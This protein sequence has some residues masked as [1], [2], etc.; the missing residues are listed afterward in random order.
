MTLD[1]LKENQNDFY[2]ELPAECSGFSTIG[3]FTPFTPPIP[4]FWF[5]SWNWFDSLCNG[6]FT[7]QTKPSA[8]IQLKTNN[9][10]FEPEIREGLHGYTKYIFPIRAKNIDSGTIIIEKDNEKIEVPFEYK[11]FKFWY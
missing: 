8:I 6:N 4:S 3:L 7:I 9:Q 10:T 5:R 2:L 11:Y 1:S